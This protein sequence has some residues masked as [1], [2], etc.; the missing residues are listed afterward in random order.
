[1]DQYNQ[2]NI[3]N[4]RQISTSSLMIKSIGAILI[5]GI[6]TFIYLTSGMTI[7]GRLGFI[8]Y[9]LL[10]LLVSFGAPY[11]ARKT[12]TTTG[13]TQVLFWVLANVINGVFL[14]EVCNNLLLIMAMQLNGEFIMALD[15][16]IMI[17][18]LGFVGIALAGVLVLPYLLKHQAQTMRYFSMVMRVLSIALGIYAISVLVV[19]VLSLFGISAPMAFLST[20]LF[21]G[22]EISVTIA[23]VF[24]LISV[25]LYV[26]TLF[27]VKQLVQYGE[28]Y[29]YYSSFL[30]A[31]ALSDIFYYLLNL[32]LQIFG[33]NNN[34]NE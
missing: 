30:I 10:I 13:A 21:G 29:E 11:C 18:V 24:L 1:M 5:V 22:N 14:G 9:L 15:K 34:D 31:S 23:V 3:Y 7:F 17:T 2:Q 32:V 19:A 20:A 26:N 8:G 16:L 25:F 28:Q 12:I 27:Q 6:I 4:T 33:M